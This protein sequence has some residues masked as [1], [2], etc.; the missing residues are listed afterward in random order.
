MR[1]TNKKGFTIVELVIVIAVIA[2][3]SAV[4]IPTFSGIINKAKLSSDQ[5]AVR[6]LNTALATSVEKPETL[7]ELADVLKEAGYN[8]KDGFNS[9]LSDY[10][11]F[12]YNTDKYNVIVLAK[13][14]DGTIYAPAEDEEMVAAF[15]ADYANGINFYNLKDLAAEVFVGDKH[16]A[17]LA[18][19]VEDELATKDEVTI[20]LY[21]DAYFAEMVTV[22]SG[23]TLNLNLN[24]HTISSTF[25]QEGASALINNKGTLVINDTTGTGKI[26]TA[27]THP[28]M[29]DIPGY[30]NNTIRNEG[31]LIL[32]GGVIE[33]TTNG[34]ACFAVDNYQGSTFT[35]NGG[36]VVGVRTAIRLFANSR[37]L[38][39][40]VVIN[41]GTIEGSTGVWI[42]IPG[43]KG[44]TGLATL[45]ITGGEINGS[46]QSVYEGSWG[47][48][49]TLVSINITGGTLGKL[50]LVNSDCEDGDVTSE[51]KEFNVSNATIT[52]GIYFNGI[53]Q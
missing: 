23:K 26:T 53:K 21:N 35:M 10:A 27:A 39:T 37:T 8:T 1:N 45:V 48:D 43:N 6:N 18:Q 12:W 3:L 14:A 30:A 52:D 31:D 36:K 33:N 15:K 11:I 2:I 50:N 24:G 38:D 28:D 29:K 46:K 16:Y 13:V 40:K 47:D 51:Y 17:T 49:R 25:T 4:L 7:R 20:D 5:Q 41:G 22:A 19:A 44:N 34:G 32:E 42:Q 9:L